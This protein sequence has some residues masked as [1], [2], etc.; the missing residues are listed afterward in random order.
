MHTVPSRL[1]SRSLHEI[2]CTTNLHGLTLTQLACNLSLQQLQQNTFSLQKGPCWSF[3]VNKP[4]KNNFSALFW[5]G[6]FSSTWRSPQT[7]W[8]AFSPTR[9]IV[10]AMS[11]V[12]LASQLYC[13]VNDLGGKIPVASTGSMQSF[14]FLYLLSSYSTRLCDP[15][16]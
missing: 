1:A 11:H 8:D 7:S 15:C 13:W 2:P 14:S 3:E 16:V 12:I 6:F 5:G 9:G 4:G 10:Y